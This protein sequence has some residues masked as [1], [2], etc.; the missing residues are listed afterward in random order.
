MGFSFNTGFVLP[1]VILLQNTETQTYTQSYHVT[2]FAIT[3]FL[4]PSLEVQKK[5]RRYVT[6]LCWP[7]SRSVAIVANHE[8]K[9]DC[10]GSET[11]YYQVH[12]LGSNLFQHVRE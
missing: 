12:V 3:S 4:Q 2:Q 1:F 10:V 7:P 11:S 6:S 5:Y 9:L 8:H